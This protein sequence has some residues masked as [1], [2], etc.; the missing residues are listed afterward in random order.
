[1]FPTTAISHRFLS[2]GTERKSV[3]LRKLVTDVLIGMTE[4]KSLPEADETVQ[5]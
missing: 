5:S 2:T 4:R 3:T 1:M